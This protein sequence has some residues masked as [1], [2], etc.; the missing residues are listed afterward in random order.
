MEGVS[1]ASCLRSSGYGGC[2]R[3]CKEHR[4]PLSCL[5]TALPLWTPF[6]RTRCCFRCCVQQW[7]SQF[8]LDANEAH[9][10][11]F[12][13]HGGGIN[14]STRVWMPWYVQPHHT[15]EVILGDMSAA[16]LSHG[17]VIGMPGLRTT[18]QFVRRPVVQHARL[19]DRGAKAVDAP[20]MAPRM[21]LHSNSASGVSL[22]LRRA[23]EHSK[24]I[25]FRTNY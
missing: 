14:E 5:T 18:L 10:M 24:K 1:V 8:A 3:P 20:S 7:M 25:L 17:N 12:A 23:R 21:L 16:L 13:R 6:A 9:W 4:Y 15:G 11:N 19:T 2:D 22:L